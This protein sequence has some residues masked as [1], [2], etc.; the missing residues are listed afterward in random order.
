MPVMRSV[1]D[2]VALVRHRRRALL[3]ARAER[4]L[5][6][7]D[8]GALQVADLGREALEAGAGERDRLQHLGVAVARDDLGRD[9]LGAEPQPAEHAAL[10]L[11]RR[12]RVGADGAA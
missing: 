6:L 7:A 8:L 9:V 2:R 3:L 11:R 4:L 10:E 12:R 5:H 1:G